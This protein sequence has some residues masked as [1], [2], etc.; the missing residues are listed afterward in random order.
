MLE[1]TEITDRVSKS[2]GGGKALFFENVEGSSI[3]V[4]INTF[5]SQRRMTA[6]LGVENFNEIAHDIDSLIHTKPPEN[7]G[8][9]LAVLPMLYRLSKFPPK[10]INQPPPCQDV[11]LT[12][13]DVD[14]TKLPVLKCWPEDGGRFITL[15]LVV[16]K[17]LTGVRNVGVYR[18]QLF[19]ARTTGMHWHVHKDGASN[20]D[21]HR[22][23]GLEK[24]EVAV[25]IGCDPAT[26][27]SATAPLPHG[28]DEFSLSGFIRNKPVE[29]S[30]CITVDLEVPATSEIVLEGYINIKERRI[31]GPFGDHTGYYSL[32]DNYPV[33]HVTA[34]THRKDPIYLSTIVGKPPMEDCYMGKATERIFLPLLKLMHPEIVD[35]DLPWEGVFHNC[36]IVSIKKRFPAHAKKIMSALWGTGQMSFAKMILLVD[37]NVNVH[38][39][40]NV[41]R[42]LLNRLDMGDGLVITQGVLDVL[43]HSSPNPLFGAK[44]GIDA[45]TP[46]QGEERSIKETPDLEAFPSF[47]ARCIELPEVIDYSIPL[48]DVANPLAIISVNKTRPGDGKEVAKKAIEGDTEGSIAV[49]LSIDGSIDPKDNSIA[50][51]KFFNNV[52][53]ARDIVL[54]SGRLFVDAT[55]KSAEEGHHREWPDELMMSNEIITLVNNK[56]DKIGLE[57]V[58]NKQADG[59][60]TKKD[61]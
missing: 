50:L 48:K 23:A 30:K 7:L 43:D 52:D 42:E 11:V 60:S 27:Y 37:E 16:T 57:D 49:I 39:Y 19:N 21:E 33:F 31:E 15:P 9:K 45:T 8:E 4:L 54:E 59:F 25:A 18:L 35:Y 58:T 28:V 1:I 2:L 26:V 34:I 38:D 32:A 44:I 5:G 24:M 36:V 29:L 47:E 20:F 61:N 56:W 51:W 14:L 46:L 17:S 13:E 3:P 40:N 12:N 53:P 22:S 41:A 55:A 6:A 10:I